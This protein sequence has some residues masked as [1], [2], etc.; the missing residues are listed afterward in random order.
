VPCHQKQV[1]SVS[2]S[3]GPAC[4]KRPAHVPPEERAR[5]DESDV[6]TPR[7]ALHGDWPW[8]AAL[9]RNGKHACDGTLV[10]DS[11]IMTTASCFQG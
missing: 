9:Y 8:H 1:L 2:C 3:G 10:S 4:G 11:W 6:F 7:Q 5:I